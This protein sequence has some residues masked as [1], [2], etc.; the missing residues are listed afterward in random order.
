MKLQ[1]LNLAICG[2]YRQALQASTKAPLVAEDVRAPI[3][4]PSGKVMLESGTDI[5]LTTGGRE[6]SATY[7]QLLG[8]KLTL[9][10]LLSLYEAHGLRKEENE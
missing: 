9:R 6:R 7:R 10:Q 3:T 2:L 8:N 5:R 4:R 1:A